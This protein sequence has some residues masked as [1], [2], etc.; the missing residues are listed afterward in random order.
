MKRLLAV[1]VMLIMLLPAAL[2]ELPAEPV[3]AAVADFAG[4]WKAFGI[5]LED[6]YYDAS[7]LE[8]DV[9]ATIEDTTITLEGAAFNGIPRQLAYADGALRLEGDDAQSGDHAAITVQLL[10]D[11][12][13]SIY[14][15]GGETGA[16]TFYMA[17]VGEDD[18]ER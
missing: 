12:T 5:G 13:I 4:T 15:D 18:P 16:F 11:G 8:S 7:I 17:R 6:S 3:E 9:V 1:L 2:A 10:A 14:M